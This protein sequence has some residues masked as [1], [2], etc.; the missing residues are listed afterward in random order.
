MLPIQDP[1]V[2]GNPFPAHNGTGN[3]TY[4]SVLANYGFLYGTFPTAPSVV[5][6]A[7]KYGL[8]TDRVSFLFKVVFRS[9]L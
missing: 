9:F 5:I 8:E 4:L 2:D 6:Y 7:A 3:M 1:T